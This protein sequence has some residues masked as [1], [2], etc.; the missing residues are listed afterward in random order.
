M[1]VSW[2]LYCYN[3]LLLIHLRHSFVC[4]LFFTIK[5]FL[6][7][8][9][10]CKKKKK[11]NNQPSTTIFWLKILTEPENYFLLFMSSL[12]S[13]LKAIW[14][15]RRNEMWTKFHYSPLAGPMI[16]LSLGWGKLCLCYKYLLR[17]ANNSTSTQETDVFLEGSS[18]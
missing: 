18:F 8:H 9:T 14:I 2:G 11:A 7:Q 13:F 17:K 4:M 12:S 1:E 5:N 3:I 15:R 6:I 16:V 10:D